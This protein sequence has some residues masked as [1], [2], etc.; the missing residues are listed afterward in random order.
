M[1][2]GEEYCP[3]YDPKQCGHPA[4]VN[5]DRRSHDRRRA[6][7]RREVM[8]P[9]HVFVGRHVI[10]AVGHGVG[11]GNEF[12]IE[13]IDLRGDEAGIDKPAEQHADNAETDDEQ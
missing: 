1:H 10:H 3:E 6:G 5:G 11:R 12:G 13:S 7:H 2:A 9:Q 8:T 4:P